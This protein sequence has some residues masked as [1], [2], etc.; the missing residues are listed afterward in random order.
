MIPT[1]T[2]T[3][4]IDALPLASLQPHLLR[5][6]LIAIPQ[7][8]PSL[9]GTVRFNADPSISLPTASIS[10]TLST[11]GLQDLIT[12][13]GGLDATMSSLRLSTG[14][15]QL[16]ALARAML[17]VERIRE[18]CGDGKTVL[19]LDEVTANVDADTEG[20]MMDVLNGEVFRGMTVLAV[21]HRLQTIVG[22]DRVV[23]LDKG[24]VVECGVPAELLEMEGSVFRAMFKTVG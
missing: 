17:M 8:A 15:A 23:V 9:P 22:M 1:P 19:L 20:K 2:G 5:S 21:A 11:V 16:F 3:L 7:D 24:S 14:Q 18:R 6:A 4:T 13:R 12:E 10:A